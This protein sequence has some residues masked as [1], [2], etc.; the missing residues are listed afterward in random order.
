MT[1]KA[2]VLVDMDGVLADWGAAYDRGLNEY[3]APS[4]IPRHADQ[5]S[6]DL[7]SG[8][9]EFE[10]RIVRDV[11]E[12]LDYY[13]LEPIPGAV[14]AVRSMR[15]YGHEVMICTSPWLPNSRCIPDKIDWVNTHIGDGWEDRIIIAKDKTIMLGD[16]LIDDKPNIKG[17][18]TPTWTQVIFDQ[19]Y[20]QDRQDLPRLRTW[21]DWDNSTLGGARP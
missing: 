6:F 19:P 2:L 14:E 11:M 5:R 4:H 17:H 3:G 10:A 7:F 20:N 21:D 15:E 13:N 16:V 8:I 18:T 12:D 1:D 9:S